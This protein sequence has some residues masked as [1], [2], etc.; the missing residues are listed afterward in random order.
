VLLIEMPAMNLEPRSICRQNHDA[1]LKNKL[2]VYVPVLFSTE[3]KCSI[4]L[5]ITVYY[6][7]GFEFVLK[8]HDSRWIVDWIIS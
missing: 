8:M 5:I 4:S 1:L 2:N 7:V 3:I 6:L